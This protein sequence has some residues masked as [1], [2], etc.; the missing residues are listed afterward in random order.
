[1][2]LVYSDSNT[3]DIRFSP[4]NAALRSKVAHVLSS[5]KAKERV[6]PE[7]K[8]EAERLCVDMAR[9]IASLERELIVLQSGSLG[10]A[11]EI[12][13]TGV[14]V[15]EDVESTAVPLPEEPLITGRMQVLTLDSDPGYRF[16]GRFSH[17]NFVQSVIRAKEDAE[18][19]TYG[20]ADMQIPKSFWDIRRQKNWDIKNVRR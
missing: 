16:Y 19:T 6:L 2:S 8:E 12:S 3:Q 18:D 14:N 1:M 11:P 9:Y 5:A 10:K 17:I 7:D 15:S 4:A 13:A 20:D